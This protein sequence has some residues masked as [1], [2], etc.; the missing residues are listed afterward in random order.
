LQASTKK[1]G[2][3]DPLT[4]GGPSDSE[5]DQATRLIEAERAQIGHEIHD[6][7]LPLIFA[8]SA[9]LSSIRDGSPTANETEER[10]ERAS[11]WL[12]DAMQVGRRLLTRVYPPELVGTLWVK[13]AQDTIERLFDESES[14]IQWKVDPEA[15]ETT[16][17]IALAAYRIV[18]EAVRNAVRHGDASE[19]VIEGEKQT[20]GIRVTIRD[21]GCGFDPS[22]VPQD[23]YG[24][25]SMNG[26][27][28]LVSGSLHV[29]SNPG[30]PTSVIF[31]SSRNS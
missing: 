27:A 7:L 11:G 20:G 19:V 26:R 15:N 8:A 6:G 31:T 12:N 4:R 25:R 13:A 21:N 9:T 17:P 28:Q 18:V 22:A 2:S 23:R 29:E 14:M 5:L 10:L 24:I 1:V 3:V 30:G 16:A